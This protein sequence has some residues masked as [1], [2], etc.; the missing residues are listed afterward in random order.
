MSLS[1]L[2]LVTQCQLSRHYWPMLLKFDDAISNSERLIWNREF[3]R[4]GDV[5]ATD[6]HIRSPEYRT[7]PVAAL[8]NTMLSLRNSLAD[9]C[10]VK[11]RAMHDIS[12]H[13]LGYYHSLSGGWFRIVSG[14]HDEPL[15]FPIEGA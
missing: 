9:I 7:D 15:G 3:S 5:A 2:D 12:P 6:A 14:G 10:G 4:R 1:L 11:H 8:R 13:A